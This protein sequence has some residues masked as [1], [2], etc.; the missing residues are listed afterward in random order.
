MALTGIITI[1][2]SFLSDQFRFTASSYAEIDSGNFQL[3]SP[4]G[5]AVLTNTDTIS[6]SFGGDTIISGSVSI[7]FVFGSSTTSIYATPYSETLPGGAS[8]DHGKAFAAAASN[9]TLGGAGSDLGL[10][11]AELLKPAASPS[12]VASAAS[13][14]PLSVSTGMQIDLGEAKATLINLHKPADKA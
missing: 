2:G 14:K 11:P 5:S 6:A 10:L 4:F 9:A 12:V 8:S 7:N 13:I 3:Q 1:N